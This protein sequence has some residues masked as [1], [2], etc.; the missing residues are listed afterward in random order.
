MAR[1]V[2]LTE[3]DINRL[4]RKVLMEEETPAYHLF[5]EKLDDIEQEL[6][7]KNLTD[8]DLDD[9]REELESEKSSTKDSDN[10]LNGTEIK[11]LNKRI[12]S[13]IIK[14]NGKYKNERYETMKVKHRFNMD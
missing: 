14:L 3:S 5:V 7:K 13:L 12:N 6:K 10:G 9:L 4:V 8:E 1:I 11:K 2:R